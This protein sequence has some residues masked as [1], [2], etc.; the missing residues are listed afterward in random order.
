[1][2]RLLVFF[3]AFVSWKHALLLAASLRVQRVLV[4]I[5][6]LSLSDS[7]PELSETEREAMATDPRRSPPL[8]L[9]QHASRVQD[10]KGPKQNVRV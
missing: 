7:E 2:Q 1:M 9:R 5:R 4:W 8:L 10:A 6:D 3:P